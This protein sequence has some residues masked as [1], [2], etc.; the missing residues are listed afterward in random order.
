[1]SRPS[2]SKAEIELQCTIDDAATTSFFP[3]VHYIDLYPLRTP[4]TLEPPCDPL[5]TP[6]PRR[7]SP[8]PKSNSTMNLCRS[9]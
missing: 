2:R 4:P 9:I 8:N 1:M 3:V 7:H 5:G 6:E